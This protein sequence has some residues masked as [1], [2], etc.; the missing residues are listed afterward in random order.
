MARQHLSIP[1][2]LMTDVMEV[3]ER[4]SLTRSKFIVRG[5]HLALE[6]ARRRFG[7]AN[8][9]APPAS[10]A[11]TFAPPPPIQEGPI[12]TLKRGDTVWFDM[13]QVCQA[14]KIEVESLTGEIDEGDDILYY[15]G[16]SWIDHKGVVEAGTL[17]R[18]PDVADALK[19]WA[20]TKL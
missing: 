7:A 8:D 20:K 12:A 15:Q 17:C 11:P 10:A 3:C 14:L 9:P 19:S 16:K 2:D 5:I 6:E 1:D 18:E 13:G 4:H